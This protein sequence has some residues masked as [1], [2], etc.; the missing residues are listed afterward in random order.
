VSDLVRRRPIR[1]GATDRSDASMDEFFTWLGAKKSA[2]I[3]L[4]VMDMWKAFRNSTQRQAPQASVWFDSF[5]VLRHL[6]AALDKVRKAGYARLSGK[7]RYF[8]GY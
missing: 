6:G 3:R 1:Y 5:D 7:D 8:I 4:A 2:G